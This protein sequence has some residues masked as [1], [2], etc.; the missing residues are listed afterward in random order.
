M[1]LKGKM[2]ASL[3]N[4]CLPI[5]RSQKDLGLIVNDSLNWTENCGKRFSNG[6]SDL[7]Q[8]KNLS[9]KTHW[10]TK[11]NA[12]TGYVVPTLTY[13]SQAWLRSK[14]NMKQLENVQKKA[15]KWILSPNEDSVH[16]FYFLFHNTWSY[17]T[18]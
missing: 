8:I 14:M 13:A 16:S 3:Y 11:L 4:Q 6:F 18:Y 5:T 17:T 10:R 2:T 9:K 15:T 12:F 1:N 7:F